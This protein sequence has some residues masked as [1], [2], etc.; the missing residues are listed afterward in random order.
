MAII[1]G[2]RVRAFESNAA[3]ASKTANNTLLGVQTLS[4]AGSGPSIPNVQ[5]KINDLQSE[6]DAVEVDITNI[7]TD[8]TNIQNDILNLQALDT[9]VY[10]G[11]WDASTNTPSLADGDG[12]QGIGPGAVLRVSTAGTQDL[13]SGSITFNV[14]DFVVYNTSDVWEKWDVTDELE[15]K[16]KV[17]YR[18]I[19]SAEALN[20]S[21]VLSEEPL[22]SSEVALDV[23][24][25]GAQF[26][27]DDF[28][29]TGDVLDWDSLGL[30][31]IIV[32]GDKVRIIYNYT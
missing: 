13:G 26:L 23:R 7:E 18:T 24:G 10:V 31:G 16:T 6:I 29:V 21:L 2:Q 4:N 9:F 8:I 20:K 30:D 28:T 11:L 14:G 1:D 25:G 32:A 15:Q 27:G 19:T 5:Q 3:W 12:G 22:T 17:E